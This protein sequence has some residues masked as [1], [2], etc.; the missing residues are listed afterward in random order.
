M[1]MKQPVDLALVK[2]YLHE[3][4]LALA[5]DQ[6]QHAELLLTHTLQLIDPALTG[7][8]PALLPT[9]LPIQFSVGVGLDPGKKRRGKPGDSAVCLIGPFTTHRRKACRLPEA[10]CMVFL[11]CA[12]SLLP[13]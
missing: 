3:L 7:Q 6:P 4:R 13:L 1:T 5:N 2:A 12:T 8:Y 9:D 11:C 10:L